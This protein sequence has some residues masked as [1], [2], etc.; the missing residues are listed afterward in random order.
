M[1]SR[2]AAARQ[3]LLSSSPD[4]YNHVGDPALSVGL[5]TDFTYPSSSLT[6]AAQPVLTTSASSNAAHRRT[7]FAVAAPAICPVASFER[8]MEINLRAGPRCHPTDVGK[9]DNHSAA[10]CRAIERAKL[11]ADSAERTVK[12][13]WF[14]RHCAMAPFPFA[15]PKLIDE[16]LLEEEEEEE[17]ESAGERKTEQ[18]SARGESSR[19]TSA[20]P[21]TRDRSGDET[22]NASTFTPFAGLRCLLWKSAGRSGDCDRGLLDKDV[23]SSDPVAHRD[24]LVT[25]LESWFGWRHPQ[26]SSTAEDDYD[27][28]N[29]GTR[30][31]RMQTGRRV[32][33]LYQRK[34]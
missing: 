3:H 20:A 21:S 24:S 16:A 31:L 1:S 4:G 11:A 32:V 8:G 28:E 19:H 34:N 13:N 14:I 5:E 15:L 12:N 17:G 2:F 26:E 22:P 23:D 33:A 6:T 25:P 30:P 10:C 9:S 18:T 7:Q 29:F 27:H